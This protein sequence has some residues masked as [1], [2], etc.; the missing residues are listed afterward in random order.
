MGLFTMSAKEKARAGITRAETEAEA[1]AAGER[2]GAASI[3]NGQWGGRDA[4]WV[5]G[6]PHGRAYS[7][8]HRNGMTQEVQRRDAERYCHRH[9]CTTCGCKR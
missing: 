8:G 3:R 5:F 7:Q 2:D 4:S 1:E 9:S 6:H